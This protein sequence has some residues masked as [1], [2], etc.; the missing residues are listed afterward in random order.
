MENAV[1]VGVSNVFSWLDL[2]EIL[3]RNTMERATTWVWV[4]IVSVMIYALQ[5]VKRLVGVKQVSVL[6]SY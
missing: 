5:V 1:K 2:G 3:N 4:C 6:Q